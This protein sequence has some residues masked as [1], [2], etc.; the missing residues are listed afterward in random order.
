DC[1]R[2]GNNAA[3]GGHIAGAFDDIGGFASAVAVQHSS[4]TA[5]LN[6]QYRSITPLTTTLRVHAWA[7]RVEGRK[8][9]LKGTMH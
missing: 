8:V 1:P 2:G 6:V 4:R 3:H 7:E 5:Y 9:L